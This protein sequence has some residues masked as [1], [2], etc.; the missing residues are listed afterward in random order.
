MTKVPTTPFLVDELVRAR[1]I[2][3]K[4]R[5]L[6]KGD[7]PLVID[8]RRADAPG[9]DLTLTLQAFAREVRL[10]GVPSVARPSASLMWRGDRIRG[11]DWT[12]KHEVV[13]FGVPTGELIRGWHEH[14]W[15]AEDQQHS[16]RIPKP[17]LS[18]EDMPS[19]VSWACKQWNI[20]GVATPL[21]LSL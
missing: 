10:S 14:Y 2:A 18:N 20:E 4:T 5:A 19:L 8:V 15:T 7:Q 6:A 16:I 9:I 12:I 13:R 1:K 11:I 17:P 21:R 3:G